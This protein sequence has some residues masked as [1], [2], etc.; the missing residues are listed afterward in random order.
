MITLAPE[1]VEQDIGSDGIG[2][3]IH[4][5]DPEHEGYTYCGIEVKERKP[6]ASAD[7]VVC[8]AEE[9]RRHGRSRW[10]EKWRKDGGS[11]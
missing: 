5:E 2:P 10:W 11:V 8:I 1:E 6:N 4:Y 9:A 7:C 3:I